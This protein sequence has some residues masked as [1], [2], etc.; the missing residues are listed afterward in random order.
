VSREPLIEV[1]E[2]VIVRPMLTI[3]DAI[4]LFDGDNARRGL[5]DKTRATY[6]GILY[7][8]ADTFPNRWDV[9]KLT[10]DDC[11]R[12]LTLRGRKHSRGTRAHAE[13]VL[14][15]FFR[16][17]YRQEKI[18]RN[19]VDRLQRTRRL[20][21]DSLDV[22]TVSSAEV[23]RLME[24]ADTWAERLCIAV[25]AYLGPRRRAAARLRLTD[26]D[27]LR[28]RLRFQ[29]KGGKTIWKPIP[30][31]LRNLLE[32]AIAAGVIVE[33]SDYLIPPEGPLVK[34]ERDDR[35]IWRIVNKIATKAG[36]KAHPH[37]L[38][39]AFAVFYLESGG[40]MKACQDLMGHS[41]PK[42]T[43]G[44]LRRLDREQRMESVRNLDWTAENRF[45][46]SRMMGAG[47]FEPP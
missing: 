38:R 39:A 40:D 26:F 45:G 23:L 32:A 41:S 10:A 42:T 31:P 13:C 44:Y 1:A 3:N 43:E 5:T 30:D 34:H 27:R 37:A 36:V 33:G 2:G 21:A 29:E 11:D 24:A 18:K 47:G 35:V 14:N 7:E 4:D 46:E 25:L 16:C 15:S 8:L 17:L 12:F 9:A 19:P 22:T 28:G 20:P 6:R